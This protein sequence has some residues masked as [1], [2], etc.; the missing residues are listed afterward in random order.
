MICARKLLI[1]SLIGVLLGGFLQAQQSVSLPSTVVPRLVN[2]SGKATD[3]K[4]KTITGATGITFAVYADQSEG[5]PLWME[6]QNVQVDAKGSYTV[7]LG[8]TKAEGLPLDLFTSGAARWLGVTINGSEEQ[9]RILLL[10]VPYALKAADAETVGGLPP[11]AFVL[12][13][14]QSITSAPTSA[15]P[16]AG[17]SASASATSPA[18]S[19]VTTSGG[20][21]NA[22]PLWT[23]GTN[24][25]SSTLTQSGSGTTA[26]IG[27]NT[28]TPLVTL[29]VNGN[30][31][32]RG[33]LALPATGVATAAAGKI[34]RTTTFTA[35]SFNSSTGAAVPQ[36]FRW[37]AE[38][39]GNDTATASGSLNL[40]Y[41]LGSNPI[42]ETG[43]HIAGN[44]HIT[45]AAGQSFPGTVTSVG[46][47]APTS[48]FTVTG[49]PITSAGTLALNWTIFP[50]NANIA[51]AIVKRDNTGSFI[52]G[53]ITG[54]LGVVGESSC[55]SCIAVQGFASGG[56]TGVIGRGTVGVEGF[57]T[58]TAT[59][60][61]G[62]YG[63]LGALSTTGSGHASAGV[64]GDTGLSSRSQVAVLG[65]SD[66][67]PAGLFENNSTQSSALLAL[68]DNET[69]PIF[70]AENGSEAF[71]QHKQY[72]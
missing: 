54:A 52:A 30:E 29:D 36:N 37:Q 72:R 68:N 71:W 19:G 18:S 43:L 9:P 63:D 6:T 61:A 44:G 66:F 62:V 23:T 3:A 8:A 24:I 48:D 59:G 60:T 49:S 12:A 58:V 27:I 1:T 41:G 21:V 17:T 56:G 64:W 69:G 65:T 35:S 67:A 40:L 25:Q 46:L 70:Y 20:T 42:A 4:N 10:S 31:T 15:S 34:S 2:F 47:S 53:S 39:V 55:A 33:N 26:K 45:F 50:T 51:N 16:S 38:P 14:P 57:A 32:V 11:S 28:A 5:A 13:A 7:Q 22:L